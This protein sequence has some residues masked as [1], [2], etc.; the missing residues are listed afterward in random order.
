M[1]RNT[2]PL[3]VRLPPVS[4]ILETLPHTDEDVSLLQRDIIW[5]ALKKVQEIFE[6]GGTSDQVDLAKIVLRHCLHNPLGATTG[7]DTDEARESVARIF[8]MQREGITV[9]DR[10]EEA[11]EW[12]EDDDEPMNPTAPVDITARLDPALHP[13]L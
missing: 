7:S 11:P 9:P 4:S 3:A 5:R 13:D 10:A 8:A 1:A 6:I 12:D 2:G